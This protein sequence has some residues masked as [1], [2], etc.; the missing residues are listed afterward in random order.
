[1][2]GVTSHSKPPA[3]ERLSGPRE[4]G[5]EGGREETREGEREGER[6]GDRRQGMREGRTFSSSLAQAWYMGYLA[7][8]KHPPPRTLQ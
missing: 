7:H 5:R 6:E 3:Q 2:T 1:M 4:G 8:N